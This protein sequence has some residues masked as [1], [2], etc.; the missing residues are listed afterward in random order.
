LRAIR[1]RVWS[2]PTFARKAEI[3]CHWRS[4]CVMALIVWPTAL[5][6]TRL[7]IDHFRRTEA[8]MIFKKMSVVLWYLHVMTTLASDFVITDLTIE[9]SSIPNAFLIAASQ[10]ILALLILRAFGINWHLFFTSFLL[11]INIIMTK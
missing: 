9:F 6:I 3:E 1:L 8:P 5:I 7:P 2:Q 11:G 10:M 4:C